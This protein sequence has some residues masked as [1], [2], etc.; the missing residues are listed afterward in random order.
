MSH[1]IDPAK[2]KQPDLSYP[3]YF[4]YQKKRLFSAVSM[5]V[6]T[7]VVS[8]G[9]ILYLNIHIPGK[10]DVIFLVNLFC[11][12]ATVAIAPVLFRADLICGFIVCL[13]MQ[14]YV[15][16]VLPDR[17]L[18]LHMLPHIINH[19]IFSMILCLQLMRSEREH[20][21]IARDM[22]AGLFYDD[23]T[24]VYNRKGILS[25]CQEH[26]E[27]SLHSAQSSLLMV[28]LDDFKPI[29]DR[30]GHAVGDE[31]IHRAPHQ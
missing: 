19:S 3:S 7:G 2:H 8:Y 30:F 13:V 11:Y 28:D 31:V 10:H 12:L 25:L 24:Q 22:H 14:L 5:L 4:D 27:R 26:F 20:Y 23:L 21:Q 18:A 17:D 1:M 29:N 6:A 16:Y 15:L 9:L